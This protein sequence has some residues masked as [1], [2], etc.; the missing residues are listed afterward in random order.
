[1]S[2]KTKIRTEKFQGIRENFSKGNYQIT[3]S[4][5]LIRE[6]ASCQLRQGIIVTTYIIIE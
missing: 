6:L 3:E 4:P 1:M 2:L 5:E